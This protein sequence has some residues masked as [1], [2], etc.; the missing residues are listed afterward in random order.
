[1]IAREQAEAAAIKLENAARF[2][3]I[4]PELYKIIVETISLLR[5][6]QAGP[7]A[8]IKQ[9]GDYHAHNCKLDR[10]HDG[11]CVPAAEPAKENK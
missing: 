9:R 3:P 5:H 1:M 10:D 7:P 6:F 2:Q 4:A 11:A 8:P